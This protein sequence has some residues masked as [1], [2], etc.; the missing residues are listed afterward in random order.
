MYKMLRGLKTSACNQIMKY[1][2]VKY[3]S[4]DDTETVFL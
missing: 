1:V 4:I 2:P 3:Y